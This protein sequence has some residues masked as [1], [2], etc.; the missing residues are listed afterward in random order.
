[1]R[2]VLRAALRRRRRQLGA[3]GFLR[4]NHLDLV[5]DL[6]FLVAA[7]GSLRV[8]GSLRL[9]R[10]PRRLVVA[11][12]Q[13]YDAVVFLRLRLRLR[14][15]G[16]RLLSFPPAP[17]GFGFLD[18]SPRGVLVRSKRGE[19]FDVS[20][21]RGPGVSNGVGIDR[22]TARIVGTVAGGGRR[23]EFPAM[24]DDRGQAYDASLGSCEYGHPDLG[25]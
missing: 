14:R 11:I 3:R 7:V 24:T 2:L 5:D 16:A 19:I 10:R 4:G 20:L 1:M 6:V 15:G 18:L 22:L 25:S 12:A 9:L 23:R 17:R 8:V 21:R 13:V